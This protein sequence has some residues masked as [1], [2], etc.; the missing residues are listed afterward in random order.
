MSWVFNPFTNKL[1]WAGSGS[2]FDPA[3]P[4]PIGGTTPAAGTFT[5]LI[6]GGGSA[7]YFQTQGSATTK[8]VE[9]KALGS[10]SNI[11]FVID[12][13]GTGAIDLAAGSSGVNISNGGTVTAITRITGGTGYTTLPTVAVSAPTTAGGVQA[14]LGITIWVESTPTV[15]SGGTGYTNGDVLTLSGGTFTVAAT[16]TVTGVSG[17]VITSVSVAGAARGSYTVAPSNPI[18]VTGG[19]GSGATFNATFGV[20][21]TIT[22]T[23]AGSGYVEQPTVTF[24]GGGGSGAAAFATIGSTVTFKSLNDIT[25]QLPSGP[26]MSIVDSGNPGTGAYL[27]FTNSST[28]N[29]IQRAIGSN[30]NVGIYWLTKGTGGHSFNTNNATATQQLFVSHTASAVNYVQVTGAATGSAPVISTQGS[31]ANRGL[32][33]QAKGTGTINIGSQRANYLRVEPASAGNTPILSAQGSDTNIDLTLTPKGTGIVKTSGTGIQLVGSTSGYVGLKGAAV[34]GSTTY[35][36]PAA[37]GT[38]GQVLATNGSATLSWATASGGGALAKQ[39]DVF[40]SGIAATYTAPANTQWVK[41]TV[42]GGGAIGG[43]TTGGRSQ[44]GS[45]GGVAIKWLSMTAGQTLIYTVGTAAVASVVSS[46][47]LSISTITANGGTAGGGSVYAASSTATVSGGTATGG[48]I[49]ITG[50]EGGRAYGTSAAITTQVCGS[51]GSCPGFGTGGIGAAVTA[52]AGGNAQGFGAGGGGALN[53]FSFGSAGSGVV[54]FE[55]Y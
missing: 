7:N 16:L 42:V 18:S 55:A 15:V 9:V 37:D 25:V 46:G 28:S 21:S 22:I 47:T 27:Q 5:T 17:G 20:N 44:G 34:A 32:E 49:N 4:G 23:N 29:A 43:A 11:A 48:D 13:K 6:G 41:I 45:A 38:N 36:L 10:D 19:T 52:G 31:D 12:S 50:G 2:S 8:A 39:T 33:I 1:D 35:T 3:N 40:T 24:S 54:I 53:S 26:A 30:T 14:T 51:G